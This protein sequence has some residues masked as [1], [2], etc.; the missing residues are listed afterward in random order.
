LWQLSRGFLPVVD[1][2]LYV[3]STAIS[4]IYPAYNEEENLV[5]TINRS[6]KAMRS[7]CH[8]FEMIIINDASTDRTG[9]MADALAAIH[10]EIRVIHNAH[11]LGQGLSLRVGFAQTAYPLV[12]HNGMDYPFDLNDIRLML[13]VMEH[14]DIVVAARR[15]RAT[16]SLYRKVVSIVNLLLVNLLFGLRLHDYNF[17]QMYRK[18]ALNGIQVDARSTAF[19]TPEILVRARDKGYRIKEVTVD[20]HPRKKGHA[21]SGKPRVMIGSLMDMLRFWLKRSR[22]RG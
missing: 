15:D 1:R 20:Y 10:P 17:V 21:T 16:Y 19:L 14:A 22:T 7:M 5:E 6:L 13:P 8:Q 4:V 12:I 18:D 2:E 9:E 11:N 3:E